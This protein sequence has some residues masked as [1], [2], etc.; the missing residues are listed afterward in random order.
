MRK[1]IIVLINILIT[2]F[3]SIDVLFPQGDSLVRGTGS[4]RGGTRG[5][6]R[7][8]SVSTAAGNVVRIREKPVA[9]EF[10]KVTKCNKYIQE[11]IK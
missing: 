5:R 2:Y 1:M 6:G 8:Y 4:P 3:I 9:V 11:T 10:D 7:G